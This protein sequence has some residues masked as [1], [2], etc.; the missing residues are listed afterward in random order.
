MPSPFSHNTYKSMR[1]PVFLFS[2]FFVSL[3]ANSSFGAERESLWRSGKGLYS[4]E[5]RWRPTGV[6]ASATPIRIE[7]GQVDLVESASFDLS[8]AAATFIDGGTL[9]LV[10]TFRN[11]VDGAGELQIASGEIRHS[12]NF[13]VL[14]HNAPGKMVMTGGRFESDVAS[15]FFFSDHAGAPVEFLMQDGAFEVSFRERS[16][17]EERWQSFMGKAQNDRWTIQGGSVEIDAG[18]APFFGDKENP[19][20][21]NRFRAIAV[22]RSSTIEI[23]GGS[24]RFLRPERLAIGEGTPGNALLKLDGG[25]L[26]VLD[27]RGLDGGIAVGVD[28]EGVVVVN[29]G[30]LTVSVAEND[31]G[32]NCGFLVGAD[33][34]YG[35]LEIN[36]GV[37]DLAGLDIEIARGRNSVGQV[38]MTGGALRAGDIRPADSAT[39]ARFQFEGGLIVLAGDRRDILDEAFFESRGRVSADYNPLADET[40]LSL[41][42][43]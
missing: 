15:G 41:P 26:E 22:R 42:S 9:H 12:G 8:R 1:R 19:G 7:G 10:G 30:E 37:V 35:S 11:G 6:P 28:S 31:A 33:G 43:R 39:S 36:G 5:Q 25:R 40:R 4:D 24:V 17:Y 21:A 18:N 27:T 14:G 32:R 16:D 34:G 3:A 20:D 13:F 23:S 29:D 2:V 38:R